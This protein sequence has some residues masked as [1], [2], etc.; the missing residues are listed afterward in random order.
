LPV[1]IFL[2]FAPVA[3]FYWVWRRI[4]RYFESLPTEASTL[5]VFRPGTEGSLVIAFSQDEAFQA[6]SIIINLLSF[7]HQAFFLFVFGVAWLSSRIKLVDWLTAA[8]WLAFVVLVMIAWLG[9]VGGILLSSVSKV[10]PA[11]NISAVESLDPSMGR[12]YLGPALN[13]SIGSLLILSLIIGAIIIA[14]S[15]SFTI[16][17][18]LRI[19]IFFAIGVLDQIRSQRDF[20]NA[21]LG[22]VSISTMPKGSARTLLLDGRAL[23]NHIKIYQDPEVVAEIIRLLKT[24]I[25]AILKARSS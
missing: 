10:W 21:V 11:L 2:F 18:T 25:P 4:K 9:T 5:K 20:L 8:L 19:V 17:G 13:F 7:I 16:I 23:F 22:S 3:L 14:I 12:D 1:L 24:E 6:L 15:L